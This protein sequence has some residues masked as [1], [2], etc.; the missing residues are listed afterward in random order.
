MNY[1][2]SFL[3][4]P[5][6]IKEVKNEYPSTADSKDT[7]QLRS[8]QESITHTAN[9]TAKSV[10]SIVISKDLV[11][12][13]SD[14]WGFFQQPTGTINRQVGGGSGF[15]IKK[16][17]TILTN[18]HVGSDPNA[19]YTV[20]LSDGT[21]YAAKVLATDP[22]NDL[23]LI[24]IDVA[25]NVILSPLHVLKQSQSPEIGSFAIAV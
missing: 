9:I 1:I 11:V 5:Q 22:V 21:E 18:K 3:D 16:D 2:F 12:Y 19:Q 15:F 20:I 13:R 10:V 7:N 23:A 4:S 25:E 6:E 8:L 14:P 24:K 17:G